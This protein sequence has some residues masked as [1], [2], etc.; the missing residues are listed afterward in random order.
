MTF[1]FLKG[2]YHPSEILNK[3]PLT[4]TTVVIRDISQLHDLEW[5][6]MTL[7]FLC[8]QVIPHHKQYVAL[9]LSW[10]NPWRQRRKWWRRRFTTTTS[11]RT[12]RSRGRRRRCATGR[13][14]WSWSRRWRCSATRWSCWA[15]AA[16][17]RCARPPT[18]SSCRW[19]SPTSWSPCSSCR[20]PSTSR[21]ALFLVTLQVGVK[22]NVNSF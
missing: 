21:S 8:I 5:P 16:S 7:M 9:F 11:R 3:T 2:G 22:I 17:R 13:W 6:W 19:P 15:S 18:T 10:L 20:L 1:E 4:G 14:C 12:C